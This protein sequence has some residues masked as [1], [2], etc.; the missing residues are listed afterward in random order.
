[1]DAELFAKCSCQKCGNHIEFPVSAAGAGIDCPHCAQPTV[2]NLI[3]PEPVASADKPSA[4][5]IL[6]AFS[7]PVARTRVSFFYQLGL[8]LVSV[9]MVL[10]PLVYLVMIAA[11]GWGVYYYATHFTYLLSSTR[12]G[13]RLWI[14]KL[15]VYLTPLFVGCVLVFFMIKPLFAR[16]PRHAQPLALNPG[17]EPTLFAFIAQICDSVGAPM[18]K[19]IDL[20]CQLNASAG[21]RRGALSLLGND[22]VLTLGLPLVAGLNLR[23]F[24]GVIAHEFGHFTQ[25][26][27]M[28]LSYVIRSVNGW[29]ARVVYERDAWDMML[30]EWAQEAEDWRIMLIVNCARAAVGFSRLLLMLLMF[31]GHGVSCFLLRQME[32]DA[33]SYEI[34]LA[35]SEPFEQTVKRLATL[36]EAAGKSYKEMVASWNMNRRLPDNF[37]AYLVQREMAIPHLQREKIE[38]TVG[39]VRTGVFDSHPSDGD[40]IRQARRAGEPGVFQLELPASVLF[41]NFDAVAK[42]VTLLHYTDDIGLDCD[43]STLRP[44]GAATQTA[45]EPTRESPPPRTAPT[46]IRLNLPE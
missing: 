5:E 33:D 24:A 31:L 30:I 41:A 27:G 38:D 4:P 14:L 8:M 29:F 28:R 25:G 2:L 36:G 35:G 46:R 43:A 40:R 11:A 23:Q 21:F 26:F 15:L 1:M 19:R 9:M 17:V 13:G 34:K 39:L 16:R 10:L 45:S 7:A 18:P 6:A 12:G 44:V 22:L 20:D 32:Y 37:P 42:Q 3:A